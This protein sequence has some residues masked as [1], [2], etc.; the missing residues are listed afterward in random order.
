[1]EIII[2]NLENHL[3]IFIEKKLDLEYNTDFLGRAISKGEMYAFRFMAPPIEKKLKPRFG[4]YNRF[5]N[6]N[7]K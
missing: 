3:I 1:M 2:I 7:E 6:N 5:Y 4:Y